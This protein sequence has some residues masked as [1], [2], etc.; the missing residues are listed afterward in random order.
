LIVDDVANVIVK[1]QP[2]A[3]TCGVEFE[4]PIKPKDFTNCVKD[5]KSFI[6]IIE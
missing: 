5:V 2:A 6:T 1:L 4:Y 3:K